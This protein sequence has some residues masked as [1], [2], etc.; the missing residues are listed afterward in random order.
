M[1]LPAE[2]QPWRPA[3]E[4][5]G[6]AFAGA[7]VVACAD[8]AAQT[9][10]Y[11]SRPV[12]VIIPFTPGGT[13]DTQMRMV[14]DRLTPRLGQPLVYDYRPGAAGSIGMEVAAR[15]IADGY[16]LV[17]GTVGSWAVTPH[18]QKLSFDPL[19]D[20]APIVLM[21]TAPAV[22]VVH[23]S[24]P[25]NSVKELISLARKRPG[26]LNYGSTGVGGFGHMCAE[27]FSTMTATR[28]THVAYK[29]AS[30][31]LADLLGGHIEVL[32]NSAV[33][34]IPQMQAGR[35][36][37]LATTGTKRLA[38]LPDLPTV[39]EAGVPG[40]ENSTWTGLGAPARTPA[41]IISR[42]NREVTAVLALPD[43]QERFTSSGAS[44]VGGSPDDFRVFLHAEHQKFG[45][46]LQ[47]SGGRSP[48]GG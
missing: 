16:T 36:R 21:A 26:A 34:T 47:K 15:A 6:H 2:R 4:F 28:M 1:A 45:R 12:R 37:A 23:P 8:L 31:A 27:L 33:V 43:V 44:V 19:S 25:A 20:L 48:A 5:F 42:L 39:A 11:P 46:L 17:A 29:G 32:F 9:P 14:A 40:Y 3:V 24:L 18:M 35:V 38:L 13:P 10:Q 41:E 30:P 7:L 22:L